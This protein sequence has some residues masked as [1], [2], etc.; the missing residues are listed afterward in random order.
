LL[1]SIATVSLSGGLQEKLYAIAAAK[2]DLVEIFENELAFFDGSPAD[3]R[4]LVG[5]L[6]L[7]ISLFQPF[8]DFEAVPDDVFAKNLDR[9]TRK[10]DLMAE[11]GAPMMLVSS[12]ASAHAIADDARAAAQLRAMAEKASERNLRL[13]YEAVAWGA[14]VRSYR[15]AWRIV[16]MADHPA[17]G[18]ILDSFHTLAVGDDPAGFAAIPADRLFH[19]Q[20]SDAPQLDMD[21]RAIGRHFRCL[22]GQ[23]SLDLAGFTAAALNAGY[24]GPLSIEVFNDELRA[25][26]NRQSAVEAKRALIHV[27]EGAR[28]LGAPA[29]APLADP[30][31]VSRLN[32]VAFIEFAV[33]AATG[34]ALGDWLETLGFARIGRHRSKEVDLYRQGEA[35][36]VLNAGA[37]SFA[38]YYHH[39]HGPS[40]CAVGLSAA[41]REGLLGRAAAFGYKRHAEKTGPGEYAMPALRAPDGSLT[42][43]VNESYDPMLDFEPQTPSPAVDAGIIR[44]D[45]I[46]RAVPAGQF[47]SWVLYYRLLL[48]LRPDPVLDLPEPH[49]LVRSMA[50]SDPAQAVRFALSFSDSNR[51]VVARSL[52]TFAGAG[53]N[54]IAFATDDIF[55][56]VAR[57][58][59]MGA[60]LLPI[61]ASYYV[62]LG[63]ETDLTPAMIARLRAHNMLYAQDGKG[64]E[65]LHAY[66]ETFQDRFFFEIVQRLGCYAGYG[67][68]NAPVRMAAQGK[69]RPAA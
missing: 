46:A 11:L 63:V 56:T 44:F 27:E 53:V 18:L 31:S 66:T 28:R 21:V 25:A 22:P 38:H 51:T 65:F 26:P 29:D 62:E 32:G 34:L 55:A 40:V 47:D 49:G 14:H 17:L 64:G 61:P 42:P 3:V 50:L 54:Q 20:L 57:L 12:N 24:R 1:H 7:G 9:A 23:G 58:Q 5:Q 48:G 33:D 39:L 13:G 37:D 69:R 52:S 6:G 16:Q 60:R 2:F 43:V 19:L 35:L 67:E 4:E 68:G 59:T 45:H 10:F 15:D 41:D 36:I 8:F 30:P